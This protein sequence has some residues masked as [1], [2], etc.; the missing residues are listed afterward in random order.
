MPAKDYQCEGCP[1]GKYQ[2]ALPETRDEPG[3]SA[4]WMCGVTD[5]FVPDWKAPLVGG[6]YYFEGHQAGHEHPLDVAL[7]RTTDAGDKAA[8]GW[9]AE[10][11]P[12]HLLFRARQAAPETAE[13]RAAK[14]HHAAME[15][16]YSPR[17]GREEN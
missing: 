2:P 10:H 15:F 1:L 11:V 5:Q 17:S 6:C 12:S 4:G 7:G 13:D 3:A 16:Q 14:L 9:L 8:V